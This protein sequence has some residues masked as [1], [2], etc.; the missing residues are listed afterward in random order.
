MP[1]NSKIKHFVQEVLGCSC[2]EEVFN[3]ICC[4]NEN[5]VFSGKK[6]TVGGRLL[7]YLVSMDSQS[8]VQEVVDAVLA[9]GVAE[10]D[11]EGF[12][13]FRLVIVS[14]CPDEIRSLVQQAFNR[15]GCKDDMTHLHVV[16]TSHAEGF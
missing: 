12:N 7:I 9:E 16:N 5:N 3:E 1:T 4:K 6:V 13:R 15:S 10:R 14:S 11:R 8:S 2:P